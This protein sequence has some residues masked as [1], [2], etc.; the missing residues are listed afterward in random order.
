MQLSPGAWATRGGEAA[1]WPGES[2]QVSGPESR[3]MAWGKQGSAP[4]CCRCYR[5]GI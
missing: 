3:A 4:G 5:N 1:K 2:C